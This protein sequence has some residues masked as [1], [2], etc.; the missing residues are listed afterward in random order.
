MS[1]SL[2]DSPLNAEMARTAAS[3]LPIVWAMA[4]NTFPFNP[5][6]KPKENSRYKGE[7][8]TQLTPLNQAATTV[9]TSIIEK[10]ISIAM[11]SAC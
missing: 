9:K 8:K 11:D 1:R 5:E 3:S 2:A 4:I 7:T 6:N 10:I